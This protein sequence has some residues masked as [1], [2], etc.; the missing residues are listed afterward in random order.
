MFL[1]VFKLP[2]LRLF[3]WLTG[4]PDQR[5]QWQFCVSVIIGLLR[6]ICFGHVVDDTCLALFVA[7]SPLDATNW[8]KH[9]AWDVSHNTGAVYLRL[10]ACVSRAR[11]KVAKS[12]TLRLSPKDTEWLAQTKLRC[13]PLVLRPSPKLQHLENTTRLTIPGEHRIIAYT[14]GNLRVWILSSG[15]QIGGRLHEAF[16]CPNPENSLGGF[17]SRFRVNACEFGFIGESRKE[18][19]DIHGPAGPGAQRSCRTVVVPIIMLPKAAYRH[20]PNFKFLAW[21]AKSL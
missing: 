20:L 9:R 17:Q 1:A 8:D 2:Q 15:D 21:P 13:Y 11:Q 7:L 14:S 5:C 4:C 10:G 6:S 12:S 19:D 18:S 3:P 16:S